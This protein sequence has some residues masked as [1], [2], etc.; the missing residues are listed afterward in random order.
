MAA[1]RRRVLL[2]GALVLAMSAPWSVPGG[3]SAIP[4]VEGMA[5]GAPVLPQAAPRSRPAPRPAPVVFRASVSG[6]LTRADVPYSWRPGCPVPPSGLRRL[7][8]SYFGFD[9]VVR[10]GTLVVSADRS[11]P[12]AR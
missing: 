12:C 2:V 3:A 8:V 11:Q 7:R 4:A 5:A 9:G 6:P 1:R 10:T